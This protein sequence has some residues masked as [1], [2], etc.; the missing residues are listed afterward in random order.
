MNI[1]IIKQTMF[2][3]ILSR[4]EENHNS[5]SFVY[6]FTFMR[7]LHKLIVIR[8]H[9]FEFVILS[10]I[11]ENHNSCSFVYSFT[12][13]RLLH[14]LIVIRS[15]KFEFQYFRLRVNEGKANS[16]CTLVIRERLCRDKYLRNTLEE[17]NFRE[18]F[19]F[20]I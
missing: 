5:C 18:I 13:M 14:K 8:S 16:L 17:R 20:V 9:K 2:V 12:F 6:S 4:I 1:S 15:H 10:R 11:E 3:V 19:F 7:L